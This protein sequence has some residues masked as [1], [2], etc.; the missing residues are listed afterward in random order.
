MPRRRR[1]ITLRSE[2]MVISR[3]EAIDRF[4]RAAAIL[5]RIAERMDAEG[6]PFDVPHA[7]CGGADSSG[8]ASDQTESNFHEDE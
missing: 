8:G 5:L 1:E 7:P 2:P 6:I 4:A 3:E